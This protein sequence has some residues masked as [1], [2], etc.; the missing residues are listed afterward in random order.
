MH[1]APKKINEKSDVHDVTSRVFITIANI[2]SNHTI[3]AVAINSNT[4]NKDA[5]RSII[6][7]ADFA[8]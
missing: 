8:A 3:G 4:I 5:A 7:D 6:E 2:T 1:K